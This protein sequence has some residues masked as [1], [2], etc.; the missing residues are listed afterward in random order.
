MKDNVNYGNVFLN[1]DL[2][3]NEIEE[4]RTLKRIRKER[5]DEL[6]YSERWYIY[7]K[8]EREIESFWG[9]RSGI[10]HRIDITIRRTI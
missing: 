9:V 4:E 7:G 5:N 10:L 3:K 2:T 6:E 1:K 8:T